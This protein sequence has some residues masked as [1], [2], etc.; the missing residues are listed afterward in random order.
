MNRGGRGGRGG[1]V[2]LS[3]RPLR[4]PRLKAG[5]YPVN[6]GARGWPRLASKQVALLRRLLGF[7]LLEVHIRLVIGHG[8][9]GFASP[10]FHGFL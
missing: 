7:R 2:I 3:P 9:G 8:S 1:G 6:E 5:H 10:A 4:S